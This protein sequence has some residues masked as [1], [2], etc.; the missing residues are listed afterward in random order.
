M[1]YRLLPS[2]QHERNW[3]SAQRAEIQVRPTRRW[4]LPITGAERTWST[5]APEVQETAIC[6]PASP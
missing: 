3:R 5:W 1:S 4:W 2:S 6:R